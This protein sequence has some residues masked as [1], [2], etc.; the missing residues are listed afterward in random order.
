MLT[1]AE[2]DAGVVAANAANGRHFMLTYA[3]IC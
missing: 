1:Y 2:A 3:D